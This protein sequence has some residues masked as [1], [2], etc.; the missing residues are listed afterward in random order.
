MYYLGQ[1]CSTFYV[2]RAT[3]SE[4]GLRGG[5]MNFNTLSEE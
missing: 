3:S 2:V 5:N 1:A 4:F